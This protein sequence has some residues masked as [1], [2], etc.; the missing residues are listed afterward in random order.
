MPGENLPLI[1]TPRFLAIDTGN[2]F[3]SIALLRGPDILEERELAARDGV[4]GHLLEEIAGLLARHGCELGQIDF[5][6]VSTGPGAFTGV[7]VGLTAAMGL[8]ES[9]G[10]RIVGVSRLMAMASLGTRPFRAVLSDARR[11]EVYAA[12]YSASLE[13]VSP[14]VVT[15]LPVWLDAVALQ[16]QDCEFLL[17]PGLSLPDHVVS[18]NLADIQPVPR[19]LSG[20]VGCVA[21]EHWRRGWAVDPAEL[22]ANYVRRSDGGLL[23]T[24]PR[25]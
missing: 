17:D 9:A 11:G 18:A 25:A 5:I 7:R 19:I 3:G 2:E 21:L 14:E 13:L 4:G 8:A 1:L 6:A 22:K 12:V 23:W 24:D 16:Q 20:A 15:A 10:C